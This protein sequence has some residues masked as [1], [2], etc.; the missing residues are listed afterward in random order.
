ME[1]QH[2][3]KE[4]HSSPLPLRAQTQMRTSISC[5][6]NSLFFC[7]HPI[8]EWKC[9]GRISKMHLVSVSIISTQS[10][11]IGPLQLNISYDFPFSLSRNQKK[12]INSMS[13]QM[14]ARSGSVMWALWST[15]S[16]GNQTQQITE[17]RLQHY[18]KSQTYHHPGP[19]VFEQYLYI[20]SPLF[21]CFSFFQEQETPHQPE[22]VTRSGPPSCLCLH[23][24]V[25]ALKHILRRKSQ[26]KPPKRSYFQK[27]I[28]KAASV[29]CRSN[30]QLPPHS[31]QELSSLTVLNQRPW[32]FRHLDGVEAHCFC[33][34]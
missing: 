26:I 12:E 34:G 4:C 6:H 27:A 10:L 1:Q 28:R 25:R 18:R 23:P 32:T 22:Q 33:D 29:H 21:V 31:A 30:N 8:L 9:E 14:Q 2:K 16:S 11:Y 3:N 5:T 13:W 15:L 17:A 24:H 7:Q 20:G 19:H